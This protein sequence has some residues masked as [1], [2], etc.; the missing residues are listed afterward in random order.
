VKRWDD[1]RPCSACGDDVVWED[2]DARW[3]HAV[4]GADHVAVAP[5][6]HAAPSG[7]LVD[8][9]VASSLLLAESGNVPRAVAAVIEQVTHE[10]TPRLCPGRCGARWRSA[11]RRAVAEVH[12]AEQ[13]DRPVDEDALRGAAFPNAG[14]PVWCAD[15]RAAVLTA[16]GRLPELVAEVAIRRDG[17]LNVA[18]GGDVEVR[19]TQVHAPSPSPAHDVVDEAIR[20][21]AAEAARLAEVVTGG[22]G[23]DLDPVQR[24]SGQWLTQAVRYLADNADAWLGDAE[25]G[26]RAGQA[27]LR[28]ATDL[29]RATGLDLVHRLKGRCPKCE[30]RALV[31]ADGTDVVSCG[32]CGA[33]QTHADYLLATATTEA[34]RQADARR[35]RL[36]RQREASA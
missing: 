6:A 18:R 25:D 14:E 12:D 30:S 3:I 10:S 2:E 13:K 26:E 33:T 34:A 31:R 11:V 27:T 5:P 7:V 20:W 23:A 29:E 35:R 36:A 15:D 22:R 4:P 17:R 19:G 28:L 9:D 24:L 16:L 32:R 21:A 1:V 8:V